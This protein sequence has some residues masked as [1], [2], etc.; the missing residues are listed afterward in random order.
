MM[1]AFDVV[2]TLRVSDGRVAPVLGVNNKSERS[3]HSST[4]GP[5]VVMVAA[6]STRPMAVVTLAIII[7]LSSI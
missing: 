5:A 2:V 1:P 7:V 4:I 3:S 6:P